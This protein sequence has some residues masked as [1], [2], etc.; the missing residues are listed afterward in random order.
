MGIDEVGI[1]EVGTDKVGIDEVGIDE[2]GRYSN[3]GRGN[4]LKGLEASTW[5][6]FSS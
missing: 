6:L 5:Q 1:D 2:V 3:Q 4:Y